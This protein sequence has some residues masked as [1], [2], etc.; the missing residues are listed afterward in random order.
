MV[1]DLALAGGTVGSRLKRRDVGALAGDDAGL[2]LNFQSN[3]WVSGTWTNVGGIVGD[4]TGTIENASSSGNVSGDIN[5]DAGGL[6][7][8]NDSGNISNSSASG[9]VNATSEADAGG[10]VG[11]SYICVISNSWATGLVSTTFEASCG[12]ARRR[13][14]R[15]IDHRVSCHRHDERIVRRGRRRSRRL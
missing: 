7:G 8:Y 4:L 9:I 1:R 2:I 12:R 13:P 11:Y 10:L 3:V 5:T 15:G 14:I 6:V